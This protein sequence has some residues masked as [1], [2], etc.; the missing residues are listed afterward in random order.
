M[1]LSVLDR[2]DKLEQRK[3]AADNEI[4]K[5]KNRVTIIETK[6]ST[7]KNNIALWLSIGATA[8]VILPY[9]FRALK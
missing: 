8:A 3:E 9:I 4:A 5:L 1:I 7:T 6:N 2:L